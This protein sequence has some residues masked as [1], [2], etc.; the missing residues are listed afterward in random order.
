MSNF[1]IIDTGALESLFA[2]GNAA[3]SSQRLRNTL[4][5]VFGLAPTDLMYSESTVTVEEFVKDLVTARSRILHGTWSTL[6]SE[7][8]LEKEAVA[9][10]CRNI[11]IVFTI[12]LDR[13]LATPGYVD[14][15]EPFIAW[16]ETNPL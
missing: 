8:P 2:A 7:L 6:S 11:L 4:K 13:Y 9:A 1:I 14:D 15:I 10:L 5:A 12:Q 3:G 16:M